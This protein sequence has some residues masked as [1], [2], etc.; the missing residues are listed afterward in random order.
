LPLWHGHQPDNWRDFALIEHRG[1]ALAAMSPDDPDNEPALGT[2]PNSY[3]A[4][5]LRNALYVE[6]QDGEREYYDLTTDPWEM[7]NTAATL[8]PARAARLHRALTAV[9][10]CHG[11]S[12]CWTAQHLPD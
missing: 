8:K 4:I 2:N 11:A 1:P 7:T 6:Y 5:R 12:D 9:K 10:N 3:E